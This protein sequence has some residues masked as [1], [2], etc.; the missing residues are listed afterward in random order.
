MKT[1]FL[2]IPFLTFAQ[3][4]IDVVKV[5]E[6]VLKMGYESKQIYTVLIDKYEQRNDTLKVEYYKIKMKEL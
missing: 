1:L 4:E 6:D 2:L 5:Y 3:T